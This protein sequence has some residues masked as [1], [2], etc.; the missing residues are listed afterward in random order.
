MSFLYKYLTNENKIDNEKG[1]NALIKRHNNLK[2]LSETFSSYGGVLAKLS[3]IMCFEE[4]NN[5]VFSDCKPFSR[6]KTIEF[7]KKSFYS[8]KDFFKNVIKID[9][10][11]IKSGSVGQVHRAIY[12]DLR[13]II[14]KVKYVGLEEQLDT[15]LYILDKVINYLYNFSKISNAMIDIKTKLRE[16]LDYKIEFANQKCMYDM[17]MNCDNIKISKLIPELCN[18][19]FLAM[20]YI[21]AESLNSFIENS[22]QE[23]RNKVGMSIIEFIFVN[24]YS[25][26]LFYSDLHYGNFLV[27]DKSILYVID[28][29][30]I[31]VI[32]D[33]LLN[34]LINLHIAIID[35]NKE[36]FYEI[37]TNI[38]IID[39]NISE[40]SKDYIYK[41]FS[42][43]YE[44]WTLDEFEYTEEWLTKAV[45]K[46]TELME[47]WNLPSNMVYLNK[48]VYGLP[49]ILTKLKLK[50]NITSFIKPLLHN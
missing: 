2:I 17:W 5:S 6:D 12:T 33:D 44:P 20:E 21:E 8:E 39:E 26:G 15:D 30:C 19:K 41:Y 24:F 10:E 49:H 50:G 7:L 18:D 9:F 16:E 47:E 37:V 31:N 3:Q 4:Q 14:I 46:E 45:F 36:K 35:Q 32:E 23:E 1:G 42:L 43:Q 27:K 48:M 25:N 22:T 38:G 11:P 34:N 29:G 13:D 28:F 40:A